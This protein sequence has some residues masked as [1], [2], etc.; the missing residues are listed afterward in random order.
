[1][2]LCSEFIDN[3]LVPIDNPVRSHSPCSLILARRC[4]CD[5]PDTVTAP[6][7]YLPD[8]SLRFASSGRLT[9]SPRRKKG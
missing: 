9:S 5:M 2:E 8:G 4:P 6:R 3:Q 1:M 7:R